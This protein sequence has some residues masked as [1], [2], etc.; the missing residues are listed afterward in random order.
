MPPE[1]HHQM[2]GAVRADSGQSEQVRRDLVVGKMVLENQAR[3]VRVRPVA[4]DPREQVD[5]IGYEVDIASFSVLRRADRSARRILSKPRPRAS[6]DTTVR[7]ERKGLT[8]PFFQPSRATQME[9]TPSVF[10]AA[11]NK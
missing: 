3:I 5:D 11:I 6:A 4:V 10:E 2:R 9:R 1:K 8:I 7:G